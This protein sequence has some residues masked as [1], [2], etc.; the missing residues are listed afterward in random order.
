MDIKD[1]LL[2]NGIP[3]TEIVRADGISAPEMIYRLSDVLI[4]FLVKCENVICEK[5]ECMI[6][7]SEGMVLGGV[8]RWSFSLGEILNTLKIKSAYLMFENS[9]KSV[10]D[11]KIPTLLIE[12]RTKIQV[13][14]TIRYIVGSGAKIVICNFPYSILAGACIVKRYIDPKLKIILVFHNDEEIYYRALAAWEKYIDICLTISKKIKETL[15][16]TGFPLYKIRDLYWK[17]PCDEKVDRRYTPKGSP[18]KIGYAGRISIDQ[19]RVDLILEIG[20]RLK[21]EHIGFQMELAGTGEY[22]DDLKKTIREKNLQNNIRYLGMVKHEHII[23]FWKDQD[24]CISCS[25]WEGHSI[26]HSE[27]MAAGVVLVITD[28]SGARDDVEDGINGFVVDIGD[29]DALVE[30]IIYL[31][32]NRACL[33]KMGRKSIEKVIARNKYMD[34]ESYWRALLE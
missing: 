7:L 14:D 10:M 11:D 2:D 3:A 26:S 34:L 16:G 33:C 4:R 13:I 17:I 22:E 25:E 30:R 32:R 29:I 23:R 6:D 15:L 28:T 18:I 19:K 31:D 21:E 8:E 12:D 1:Q 20:E 9:K 24:I 27:A 5:N